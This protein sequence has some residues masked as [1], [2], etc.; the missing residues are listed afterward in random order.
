M[1]KHFF[2]SLANFSN[3]ENLWNLNPSLLPYHL[4]QICFG[5]SNL[6]VLSLAGVTKKTG[7]SFTPDS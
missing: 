7:A 6:N 3:S 5:G 1:D 4:L 2:K